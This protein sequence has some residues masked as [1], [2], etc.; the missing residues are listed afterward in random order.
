[1]AENADAATIDHFIAAEVTTE[2]VDTRRIYV[3][4]WSNGAA[5]GFFTR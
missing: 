5:M 1:M 4:G 3:S 2:N